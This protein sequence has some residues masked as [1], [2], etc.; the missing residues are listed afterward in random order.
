[1][2]RLCPFRKEIVYM[3][4]DG[5]NNFPIQQ[6]EATFSREYFMECVEDNCMMWNR[7]F[8]TCGLKNCIG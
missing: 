8:S 1:M 3:D 4:N 2:E 6:N 5:D 7:P